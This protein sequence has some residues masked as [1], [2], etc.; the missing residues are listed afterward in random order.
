MSFCFFSF[1]SFLHSS[2]L[3]SPSFLPS[4]FSSE[5]SKHLRDVQHYLGKKLLHLF[6]L[7]CVC[8]CT[9]VCA[10]LCVH[11]CSCPSVPV[12]ARGVSSLYVGP[13]DQTQ[14]LGLGSK[15]LYPPS[16]LTGLQYNFKVR[17]FFFFFASKTSQSASLFAAMNS[18]V[19][20]FTGQR[21]KGSHRPMR[22]YPLNTDC[23]SSPNTPE[24][25]ISCVRSCIHLALQI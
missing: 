24:D 5:P 15:L 3:F 2:F 11:M 6:I 19:P 21:A 18:M 9:H 8:A 22:R 1:L 23:C 16:G 17:F 12:E 20:P 7:F 14:S 4:F 25:Q 13:G 10:H